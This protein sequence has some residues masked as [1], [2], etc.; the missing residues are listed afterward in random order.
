LNLQDHLI[1]TRAFALKNWLITRKRP[2]HLFEILFWPLL[3]LISVGL[4]ARFLDLEARLVQFVLVG[5]VAL[6]IVQVSQIDMAYVVLYSIWNRSLKHEMAAPVNVLHLVVGSWATGILHAFLVFVFLNV[7]S[8]MAF[9]VHLLQAGFFPLGV[10]FVGLVLFGCAVGT[11]V[12][13]MAFH[14]GGR[15]HVGATFLVS[16]LTVLSGIYYPIDVLPQPVQLLSLLI[17]LTYFLEYVRGCYGFP[18][19]CSKPL[20]WG[21]LLTMGYN[22]LSFFLLSL[23]IRAARQKGTLLELSE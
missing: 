14:L 16:I 1:K 22:L 23:S 5:V 2:F 9:R 18:V 4:L 17:P 7:F 15:A 10:L 3:G 8:A 11:A 13:A 19:T 21:F 6:N 20:L 12:C